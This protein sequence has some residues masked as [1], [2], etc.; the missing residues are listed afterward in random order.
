M[1]KKMQSTREGRK[2]E[3][4]KKTSEKNSISKQ[5]IEGARGRRIFFGT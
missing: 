3:R 2:T 1:K 5:L 4:E